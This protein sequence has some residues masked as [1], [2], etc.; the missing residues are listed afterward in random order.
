[1]NDLGSTMVWPGRRNRERTGERM[2]FY[3]PTEIYSEKNCVENHGAKMASLGR[4]ALIVT[5]RHSSRANGSLRDVER[6]LEQNQKPYVLF[7]EIEENPSMETIMRGRDLGICQGADFVIGIGGGSPMDAAKAIALMMRHPQEGMDYLY[8]AGADS[9]AYPVVE[10]PTTCGTGSEATPY[11]I[12]T[13][14]AKRTKSSLPHKIYPA[15]SLADPGYLAFA[16]M[17][18]LQST[19][20]DT[21]GHFVESYVNS[22]G[23]DFSRMLVRE[24]LRLWSQIKDV[25]S[26]ERRPKEEDYGHLLNAATLGG[27]AITHTGTSLPHGLSY[28]VTYERHIAHG[29]A[30][31]AFLA[32]YLEAA[33]QIWADPVLEMA[34]FRGMEEFRHYIHQVLGEVSMDGKLRKEAVE[35]LL[36]N[37]AKLKNCPF[38]VDDKRLSG[39]IEY[40]LDGR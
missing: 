26:Q 11:A 37:P 28:Y 15:L 30:V 34:G 32:G 1:M 25:L 20:I 40:S 31:G 17:S 21:L 27:M 13:I 14:H 18:V 5:G 3:M 10:V 9:S 22:N 16:P 24:G 7:D 29:K 38:P 8:K 19:A 36:R 33:G 4:K 2:F 35:G 6:A 23:T 39:I 12:L